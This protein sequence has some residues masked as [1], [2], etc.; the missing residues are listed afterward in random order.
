MAAA[1]FAV[2]LLAGTVGCDRRGSDT[3]G[4]SA[5]SVPGVPTDPN[6]P[7]VAKF[8]SVLIETDFSKMRI[9]TAPSL[10]DESRQALYIGLRLDPAA[11]NDTVARM[12]FAASKAREACGEQSVN[13]LVLLPEGSSTPI[14]VKGEGLDQVVAE[15][16]KSGRT[17]EVTKLIASFGQVE[18]AP[19][20]SDLPKAVRGWAGK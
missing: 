3:G 16:Y 14:A 4:S 11:A 12:V 8:K 6:D 10:R 9:A 2:L 15:Y 1:A 19:K 7:V 20:R 5:P 17:A 13:E 18:P